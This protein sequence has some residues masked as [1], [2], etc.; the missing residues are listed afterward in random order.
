M[1]AK[2]ADRALE[3]AL[4]DLE[5][6]GLEDVARNPHGAVCKAIVAIALLGRRL[7]PLTT[8]ASEETMPGRPAKAQ[9]V[10]W[11]HRPVF[12]EGTGRMEPA[13]PG[14]AAW[15]ED[16]VPVRDRVAGI[17]SGAERD[18][19]RRDREEL[20]TALDRVAALNATVATLQNT[21]A[22][23]DRRV[24]ELSKALDAGTASLRAERDRLANAVADQAVQIMELRAASPTAE[25]E[26]R[27][28]SCEAEVSKLREDVKEAGESVRHY[29]GLRASLQAALGLP[30]NA[31]DSALVAKVREMGGVLRVAHEQI[32]AARGG[33]RAALGDEPRLADAN[34]QLLVDRA[35]QKI[36]VLLE[37]HQ[38]E[39]TAVDGLR[40][41]IANAREAAWQTL[42]P[43]EALTGNRTLL[44]LID[45][46]HEAVDVVWALLAS[47]PDGRPKHGPHDGIPL[48]EA[49]AHVLGWYQNAIAERT[50][51][52]DAAQ[53]DALAA[54]G[55]LAVP[56]GEMPPGSTVRRLVIANRLLIGE[57]DRALG[58]DGEYRARWQRIQP[59]IKA[60]HAWETPANECPLSY[61][62]LLLGA[63]EAW[64]KAE[65]EALDEEESKP[66]PAMRALLG[67]PPVDDVPDSVG[68]L[69]YTPDADGPVDV[70]RQPDDP[71]VEPDCAVRVLD[72]RRA[73][74]VYLR[75]LAPSVAMDTQAAD[76]IRNLADGI[77]RGAHVEVEGTPP[78]P[79]ESGR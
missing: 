76:V 34:M 57:R 72:E 75:R 23:R 21:L 78:T 79:S 16:P 14:P 28:A 60:L 50:R 73:I 67:G 64:Q 43:D 30:A 58:A 47:P 12:A 46:A 33:L 40:A 26:Q 42:N 51:E 61:E 48:G 20:G 53:A 63:F 71:G 8:P 68:A 74:V 31:L 45:D 19:W 29:A 4:E 77:A 32:E 18:L 11:A 39:R 65:A 56:L 69:A 1:D 10:G 35:R 70:P 24:E 37:E 59:L 6:V 17:V 62:H 41:E 13:Y 38:R 3:A 49:V 54:A 5:S 7:L 52:R 55:C 44:Q 2:E 9:P 36:A 15:R 25:T 66:T 27:L 22:A